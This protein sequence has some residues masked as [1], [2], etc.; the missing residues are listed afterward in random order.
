MLTTMTADISAGRGHVPDPLD[1]TGLF[2]SRPSF[3]ERRPVTV[4]FLTMSCLVMLGL[5][6]GV[7]VGWGMVL[8]VRTALDLVSSLSLA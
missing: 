2:G 4:T 5:S 1:R 8:A 3:G 6:L 7:A